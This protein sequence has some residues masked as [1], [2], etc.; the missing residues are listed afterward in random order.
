MTRPTAIYLEPSTRS[1]KKFMV[2]LVYPR[3]DSA[4]VHF[5]GKG[6]SDYTRHKDESRK[7]SYLARHAPNED[8][9]LKGIDTAGFWSRHLLWSKPSLTKAIQYIENKFDVQIHRKKAP[10]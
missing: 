9:T 6:Y 10:S 3:K 1:S 4:K 8:W 5:G 2:T 7:S